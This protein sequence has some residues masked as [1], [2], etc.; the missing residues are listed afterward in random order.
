MKRPLLSLLCAVAVAGSTVVLAPT[1]QAGTPSWLKVHTPGSVTAYNGGRAVVRPA[2]SATGARVIT[3]KRITVYRKGKKGKRVS[4]GATARLA[5]GAYRTVTSGTYKTY[6]LVSQTR[7]R[8]VLHPA[9]YVQATCRVTSAQ[10]AG[11]GDGTTDSQ[12]TC[13]NAYFPTQRET[14]E[15]F[16]RYQVGDTYLE[17][18]FFN[19][20][21][22]TQRYSVK[23][24]SYSGNHSY[25]S[26][27][28]SLTV[29]K[30]G[31]RKVFTGH[32]TK[33]TSTFKPPHNTWEISYSFS[34]SD[35][36]NF[37]VWVYRSNGDMVDLAA[38][39][40]GTSGRNNF[41]VHSGGRFYLEVDTDSYCKWSLTVR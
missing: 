33:H 5:P 16:D 38:N 39:D 18:F 22:V 1:A 25:T 19:D 12:A 13:S 17:Y 7:T 32:G 15:E 26:A 30:G 36:T 4:S 40:L 10:D 6:R 23:V 28:R 27:R 21:Y 14:D 2:A 29:R 9:D 11:F 8:R 31:Y 24:R 3:S 41:Y 37:A 35:Y 34:C 20:E